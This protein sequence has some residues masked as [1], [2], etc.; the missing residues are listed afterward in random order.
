VLNTE[1]QVLNRGAD[2]VRT[3][4]AAITGGRAEE[5]A[6]AVVRLETEFKGR[7]PAKEVVRLKAELQRLPGAKEAEAKA[8][9]VQP[10][11]TAYLDAL[12]KEVEGDLPGAAAALEAVA[13]KWPDGPFAAAAAAKAAALRAQAAPPGGGEGTPPA[14]GG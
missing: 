13:A 1:A 10:Q 2:L 8:R 11:R 6:E 12:M 14:M 3:A 5:A 7:D 9:A 4:R